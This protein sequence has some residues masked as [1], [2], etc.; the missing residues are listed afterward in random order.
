MI[1]PQNLLIKD[2]EGFNTIKIQFLCDYLGIDYAKL[3]PK[4]FIA[5]SMFMGATNIFQKFFN[6]EI[7][8]TFDS[9]LQN[10]RGKIDDIYHMSGTFCHAI[11]RLFGYI[12]P[13]NNLS[14]HTSALDTLRI[15]NKTYRKV[16]LHITYNNF[17]Y[18]TEDINIY[19]KIINRNRDFIKIEWLHLPNNPVVKYMYTN[20]NSLSVSNSKMLSQ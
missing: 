17:C 3:H 14:I 9:F 4:H 12:M 2:Q 20:K 16:H 11:E 8:E 7:V 10:E 19:G 6:E 15:Y 1:G 13:A 5:G 18:L